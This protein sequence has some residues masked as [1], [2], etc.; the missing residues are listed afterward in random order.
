MKLAYDAAKAEAEELRVASQVERQPPS[1]ERAAEPCRS[2]TTAERQPCEQEPWADGEGA[3]AV[4]PQSARPPSTA[5][6]D[7]L[8][9]VAA[10]F[11]NAVDLQ[12]QLCS[13]TRTAREAGSEEAMDLLTRLSDALDNSRMQ[14]SLARRAAV[15]WQA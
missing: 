8:E 11:R 15:R 5:L 4:G 9:M 10:S 13:V 7:L 1:F 6:L 2:S 12:Q 3:P 14:L